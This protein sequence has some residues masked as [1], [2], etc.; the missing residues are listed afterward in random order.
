MVESALLSASEYKVAR[1]GGDETR[2]VTPLLEKEKRTFVNP[3]AVKQNEGTPSREQVRKEAPSPIRREAASPNRREAASPNRRE[4]PS[5]ARNNASSPLRRN[6][7][8]SP[9]RVNREGASPARLS[10]LD[11][12]FSESG[13]YSTPT[14]RGLSVEVNTPIRREVVTDTTYYDAQITHLND[15][16]VNQNSKIAVRKICH[17]NTN[18]MIGR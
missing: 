18:T 13:N 6:R 5:P 8:A 15:V 4:A 10:R 3:D 12:K 2:D 1:F 14:R 11:S 16:I 7:E 17:K 9:S